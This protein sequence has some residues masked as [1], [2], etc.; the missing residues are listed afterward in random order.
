M[1]TA[2]GGVAPAARRWWLPALAAAL[3]LLRAAPAAAQSSWR[4]EALGLAATP[5]QPQLF[6]D[7]WGRGLGIGG[8]L[9]REFGRRFELG[10]DAEFVQFTYEGLPDRGEF[11]G[12][13]RMTRVAMPLRVHLWESARA[14]RERL[15][16]QGSAGWGHQSIAGIFGDGTPLP[17]EAQDGLA[18]TGDFRFSRSLYRGTRWSA[19]FRYTWF[20]FDA[21]S[22]GHFAFVLG[23][24]MPLQGSRPH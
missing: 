5:T 10:V 22:P 16:L 6:V 7:G 20:D 17:V 19:G 13:R 18:V 3:V 21:E 1:R 4:L 15:S 8:S 23:L 14:G 9:R 11:G 24:E 12:E 2:S